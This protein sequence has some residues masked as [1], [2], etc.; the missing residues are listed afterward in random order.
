M[1]NLLK[2]LFVFSSLTAVSHIA[3]A[4]GAVAKPEKRYYPPYPN[5]NLNSGYGTRTEII[6]GEYLAKAGDCIACHT[7]TGKPN[8]PQFAGGLGIY[9]PFGMFYSPNITP[10]K[11]YGIGNWSK[12]QFL[13]AMENGHCKDGFCYPVFPFLYFSRMKTK[14]LLDIRA[15]LMSIPAVAQPNK[16]NNIM[17]PFGWRF[18]QLGWRILFFYPDQGKVQYDHTQSKAWNRGR[19]LVLGPGHCGMCHTP[20]NPLGAEE[21]KYFL[22]GGFVDGY[23]APDITSKGLKRASVQDVVNVFKKNRMLS[24]GNVQGPMLEVN[25]D[26]LRYLNDADLRAIAVYLKTVKSQYPT[27]GDTT[28]GPN[29]GKTIYSKTCASCHDTGGAGAPRIGDKKEW[30]KYFDQGIHSMYQNAINGIGSMP[31]KGT[32]VTCTDEQIKAVVDYIVKE[33]KYGSAKQIKATS[34]PPRVLNL[35]LGKEVYEK[36]CASCHEHGRNGAPMTGNK[37]QWQP[38]LA[39]NMDTLF[40]NTL[41][42][43]GNMPAVKQYCPRCTTM[44]TLAAVRYMVNRSKHD[45]DSYSLW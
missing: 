27:G 9:T 40:L 8:R 3:F 17:F 4:V 32:C 23:Y 2:I 43:Y 35:Q 38:I 18:L 29:T 10:D 15:Y 13:N 14:D 26:S 6:H 33:T 37:K 16:Q 44:E 41:H 42:G 11:Q 24:G 36:T 7:E 5:V 34:A 25:M 21:S 31:P 45:Q 28:V 20:L 39:K 12:K 19:Y 1:R 22:T 30:Q